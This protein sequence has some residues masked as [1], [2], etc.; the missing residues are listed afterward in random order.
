MTRGLARELGKYG[1]H[2]QCHRPRKRRRR[3]P[4]LFRTEKYR[5]FVLK[6]RRLKSPLMPK[7]VAPLAVILARDRARMILGRST[8]ID[9]GR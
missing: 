6:Q 8:G 4:H 2:R 7:D 9:G 1:Q 5:A 3:T